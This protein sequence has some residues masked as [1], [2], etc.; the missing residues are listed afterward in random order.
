MYPFAHVGLQ[1]I[2]QMGSV[3]DQA[4]RFQTIMGVQRRAVVKPRDNNTFHYDSELLGQ[5]QNL[6]SFD[7]HRV[8]ADQ[9]T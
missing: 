1:K 3:G 9:E 6:I 2:R 5:S 4:S 8:R 7:H